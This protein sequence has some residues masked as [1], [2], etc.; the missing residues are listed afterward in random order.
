ML[1]SVSL[2]K[3]ISPHFLSQAAI[4]KQKLSL[5]A[6]LSKTMYKS[7]S[8]SWALQLTCALP[9]Q[10]KKEQLHFNANSCKCLNLPSMCPHCF[11]EE[12]KEP[13]LKYKLSFE[14]YTGLGAFSPPNVTILHT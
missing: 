6:T 5:S 9:I 8:W 4:Q 14:N 12:E 10:I 13:F 7:V 1:L 2:L 11:C 3:D